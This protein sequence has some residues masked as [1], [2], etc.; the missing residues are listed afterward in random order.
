MRDICSSTADV[1]FRNGIFWIHSSTYSSSVFS[2]KLIGD[3]IYFLSMGLY[4]SSHW[5]VTK[6]DAHAIII[7]CVKKSI[8]ICG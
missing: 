2:E 4:T 5:Y 8:I 1:V 6:L 7:P 3:S